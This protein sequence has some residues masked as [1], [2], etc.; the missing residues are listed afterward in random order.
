[1]PLN[2]RDAEKRGS[3]CPRQQAEDRCWWA[4]SSNSVM[5]GASCASVA[6]TRR[7]NPRRSSFFR[8]SALSGMP[9]RPRRT[10]SL[11]RIRR[12]I[13]VVAAACGGVERRNSDVAAN[14]SPARNGASAA[15]CLRRSLGV[16]GLH[17]HRRL[18]PGCSLPS[19]PTIFTPGSGRRPRCAP[20]RRSRSTI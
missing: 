14:P 9:S 8:W 7:K 6:R 1:M 20:A 2:R 10:P 12:P 15:G 5:R 4:T 13:T 18:R 11:A 19:L 17:Q 3:V 16:A